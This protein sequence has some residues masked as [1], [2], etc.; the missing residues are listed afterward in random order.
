MLLERKKKFKDQY[1][2]SDINIV[3]IIWDLRFH[4]LSVLII[5]N[6]QRLSQYVPMNFLNVY[7]KYIY[8]KNLILIDH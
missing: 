5:L 6:L 1:Y 2:V 4:N 7:L 8:L 3:S